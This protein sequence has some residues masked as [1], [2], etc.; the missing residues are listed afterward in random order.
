MLI[1]ALIISAVLVGSSRVRWWWGLLILF[2]AAAGLTILSKY[3]IFEDDWVPRAGSPNW[4]EVPQAIFRS[5]LIVSVCYAVSHTVRW[6][7]SRREN[8][9]RLG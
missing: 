9:G 6:L 5:F 3:L 1:V 2:W 7:A 4:S 8:A